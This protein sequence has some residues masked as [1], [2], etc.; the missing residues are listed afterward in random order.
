MVSFLRADPVFRLYSESDQALL[1]S[2]S[3]RMQGFDE[4]LADMGAIVERLGAGRVVFVTHVNAMSP[5]GA[6]IPSRDKVI[7][8]VKLAAERLGTQIFDPTA[9]MREFGQERAMEREGLDTTHFTNTFADRWY[10]HVHREF[11]LPR[12][13]EAGLDAGGGDFAGPSILAES[14]AAALEFDDSSK[15]R[16]SFMLR[17]RSIRTISRCACSAGRSAPGSATIAG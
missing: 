1:A 17:W 7:R 2:I 16:A 14:I 13:V 9:M 10:T 12:I 8:W 4:I 15:A 5:D 3:M 6:V 11:V